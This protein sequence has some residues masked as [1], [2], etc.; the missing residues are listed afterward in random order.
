MFADRLIGTDAA[1]DDGRCHRDHQ[2][3][4][5]RD[6]AV[7]DGQQYVVM[8]RVADRH[9][10]LDDADH[11]AA[12][13]VDQHH[14]DAGNR[15]AADELAGTVHGAVKI[16]FLRDFRATL[17]CRLFA[18]Q[19]GIQ[20]GVDCHLL[21]GHG[22]QGK[23]CP[24]FGDA[25][26]TLG[27]DDKVDHHQDDE[28]HQT[29]RV[30]S[31]DHEVPE[32]FDDFAGGI[33]SGV[34]L[35]QHDAGGRDVERQAQQRGDQQHRR[36]NGKVEGSHRVERDQHD[37]D[38]ERDV[39]GKQHV[40]RK[41]RQRQHHHA[42]DHEDQHGPGHHVQIPG[43]DRQAWRGSSGGHYG[44]P[45]CGSSWDGT[46]MSPGISGTRPPS[47]LKRRSWNT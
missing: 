16:R 42:H 40:E 1:D 21:A 47:T 2:R 11:Q 36:E 6:Q 15:V 14:Q 38:R 5:L 31:A 34:S 7:A 37:H 4:D 23:A 45:C 33:P 8:R 30:I 22:V 12:D 41:R 24:D 29:D 46:T 39:E 20:I 26:G 44:L 17:A 28:D 35:Q 43:R 18:D 13:D 27:D 25:A 3:R 32:G 10:V 19:P 9:V